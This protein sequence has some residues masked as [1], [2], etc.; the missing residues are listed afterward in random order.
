MIE[1]L[2]LGGAKSVLFHNRF[3]VP[4]KN[5]DNVLKRIVTEDET[6]VHHYEPVSNQVSL[7]LYAKDSKSRS[8]M[9]CIQVY[10]FLGNWLVQGLGHSDLRILSVFADSWW[11]L[12]GRKWKEKKQNSEQPSWKSEIGPIWVLLK[13]NKMLLGK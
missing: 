1:V 4:G 13:M 12:W 7:P 10:Y 11:N 2:F 8:S 3:R 9:C 6:R 5:K